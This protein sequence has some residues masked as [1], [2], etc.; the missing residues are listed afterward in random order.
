MVIEVDA[1]RKGAD[2]AFSLVP[3]PEPARQLTIAGQLKSSR[4][5]EELPPSV[6]RWSDDALLP[7]KERARSYSEKNDD[8]AGTASDCSRRSKTSKGSKMTSDSKK[9]IQ[10]CSWMFRDDTDG[11]AIRLNSNEG[12]SASCVPT[13]L[14]FNLSDIVEE[15]AENGSR[16][17]AKQSPSKQPSAPFAEGNDTEVGG[18]ALMTRDSSRSGTGGQS[19]FLRSSQDPFGYANMYGHT[20]YEASEASASLVNG[21]ETTGSRTGASTA[22]TNLMTSQSLKDLFNMIWSARGFRRKYARECPF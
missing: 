19:G 11:F 9:Y 15:G 10:T 13:Q 14:T 5:S 12:N 20:R 7:P 8:R 22:A 21:S 16:L 3:D 17:S 2:E 1:K 18:S 4:S 6:S